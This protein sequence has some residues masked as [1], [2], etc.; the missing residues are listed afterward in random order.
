MIVRLITLCGCSKEMPISDGTYP[1][2]LTIP[3][4]V[5]AYELSE[6]KG[7]DDGPVPAMDR[8]FR[9]ENH[10]GDLPVYRE[11]FGLM[12]SPKTDAYVLR[13]P[14]R[15]GKTQASSD[16]GTNPHGSSIS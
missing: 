9:Y 10:E 14:P 5:T 2:Y 6:W 3:L 8:T 16:F 15:S 4:R 7:V 12:V 11:V 13:T 1:E